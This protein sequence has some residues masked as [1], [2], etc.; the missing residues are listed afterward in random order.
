MKLKET[1]KSLCARNDVKVNFS[2][3]KFVEEDTLNIQI[4]VK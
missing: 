1:F 2:T 4:I 3:I